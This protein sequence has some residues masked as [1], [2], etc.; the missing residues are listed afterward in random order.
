MW[1]CG[2]LFSDKTGFDIKDLT[3]CLITEDKGRLILNYRETF[4][5]FG[6]TDQYK[7]ANGIYYLTTY[8][9]NNKPTYTKKTI[10]GKYGGM[11]LRKNGI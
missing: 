10:N 8:F 9:K 2:V 7:T 3:F 6:L 5:I 1:F 11:M 4:S